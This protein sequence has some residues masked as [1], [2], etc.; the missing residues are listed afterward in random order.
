VRHVV[1]RGL[2]F[3]VI[4]RLIISCIRRRV[5]RTGRQGGR[6]AELSLNGVQVVCMASNTGWV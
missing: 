4:S 1:P 6:R 2:E 3:I 5:R